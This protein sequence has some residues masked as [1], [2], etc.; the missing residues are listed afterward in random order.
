MGTFSALLAL[1]AGKS[2]VTADFPH[3]GQWR[4]VL[5][6]S[7]ICAWINGWVNNRKAGDLKR[8]R[9][10]YD[11]TTMIAAGIC[12]HLHFNT[13]RSRQNY[14]HFQDIFK[15]I[16][17]NKNI[18]I[19]TEIS[20]KL[21][22]HGPIDNIPVLV[23]IMVWRRPGDKPL[24]EPMMVRLLTH[25][26]VTRLQWVETFDTRMALCIAT[27]ATFLSILIKWIDPCVAK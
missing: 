25:I 22:P 26:C 27:Y 13:L 16:F 10:H 20:P 8:H 21:V 19:S 1:C 12:P 14:R 9:A 11:V 6:F 23:Q 18:W 7:L 5:M 24:S 4:G 3:K 15:Y 2:P 17:L